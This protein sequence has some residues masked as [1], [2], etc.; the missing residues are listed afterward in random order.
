MILALPLLLLY[1][2]KRGKWHK[3][4]FYVY[5]PT[6]IYV[7]YIAQQ[8]FVLKQI[9]KA[10]LTYKKRQQCFFITANTAGI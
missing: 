3:R 10:L 9:K 4:F 6:H 7:L 2:G 1:N 8:F 5:Y